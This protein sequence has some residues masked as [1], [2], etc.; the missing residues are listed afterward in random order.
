MV[1]ST[2]QAFFTWV[3]E[4]FFRRIEIAGLEHIPPH[5][6]VLFVINHPNALIDPLLVLC[7]AP[8]PVS[9]L[10]KEPLFRMPVIGWFV[11]AMDAIPV[12]RTQDAADMTKN[13]ATF[14]RA[15]EILERDG[16]IAIAPEGA[17]HSESRLR[18]FKTGAARIALGAGTA[19]PVAIIPVGLDYSDKMKF[20]SSVLVYFGEP[21]LVDPGMLP[22]DGEPAGTTAADLTRAI[23]D[24]LASVVVQ[25]DEHE[26]LH[27]ARRI[28][29]VI[30]ADASDAKAWRL[31]DS[32][33]VRRRVVEG[34]RALKQHDAALLER[35]VR[36][37]DRLER[38]FQ[39]A[40]LDPSGRARPKPRAR[41]LAGAIGWLIFRILIFIP[42]ALPGLLIHLPA[43][44]MVDRTAHYLTRDHPD[45]RATVKVIGAALF[46]PMTWLLIGWLVGRSVGLEWGLLAALTAPFAGFAAIKLAERSDRFLTATR[47]LGFHLFEPEHYQR[48]HRER[49]QL[50]S[51]L[52]D[53]ARRL[54]QE[55]PP[56]ST[57]PA[58]P[59]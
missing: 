37:L 39:L 17:S 47:A 15:R 6:P 45:A 23:E 43:Y 53:L 38:A 48:L 27:L 35:F 41:H 3:L 49:A 9:F 8:R 56:T 12:F 52:L 11:R 59:A 55:P 26:A 4:L 13:R 21:L 33:A 1:R 54:A 50:R 16:A 25:A 14:K 24:R 34:H 22:A 42:L 7:Y 10:A 18:P 2:L 28:D 36:R 30:A 20:R 57:A 58:E 19:A 29:R 51:D 40:G 46:Y 44:W 31:D 32:W 5:G